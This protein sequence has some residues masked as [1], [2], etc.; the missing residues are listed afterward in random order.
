MGST[1]LA[2]ILIR[3]QINDEGFESYRKDLLRLRRT[4]EQL[5]RESPFSFVISGSGVDV[6]K[7]ADVTVQAHHRRLGLAVKDRAE[8]SEREAVKAAYEAE[9]Q[10]QA[11]QKVMNRAGAQKA[12]AVAHAL[13]SPDFKI[14]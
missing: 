6:T 4:L 12:Y 8:G 7:L 2:S 5:Q 13:F 3:V 11:R 9:F 10:A 1:S 14:G